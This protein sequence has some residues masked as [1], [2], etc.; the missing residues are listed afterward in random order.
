MATDIDIA[1]KAT[2]KPIG[3]IAV[4]NTGSWQS[5]RH[6]SGNLKIGKGKHFL[7]MHAS[8]GGFNVNYVDFTYGAPTDINHF[9]IHKLSIY[10]MPA[11]NHISINSGDFE[12]NKIKITDLSGQTVFDKD[13]DYLSN[14]DLS[15][16]INPGVY[17]LQ[18]FGKDHFTSKKIII[19]KE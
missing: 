10:P 15:I 1:R 18:L 11:S 7:K 17:I 5:W 16:D 19:M 4:P 14:I 8:S 2:M 9:L 6:V 13:I 3:E 12:F